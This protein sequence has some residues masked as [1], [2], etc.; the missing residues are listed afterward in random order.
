MSNI[1]SELISLDH[2]TTHVQLLFPSKLLHDS[3][4]LVVGQDNLFFGGGQQYIYNIYICMPCHMIDNFS[5][6]PYAF[7]P[8]NCKSNYFLILIYTDIYIWMAL[9]LSRAKGTHSH[10][11]KKNQ[12]HYFLVQYILTWIAH[13]WKMNF[14]IFCEKSLTL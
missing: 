4:M 13:G 7:C 6:F 10:G 11:A 12:S 2:I 8:Q 5:P 3:L 1:D 14:R 9:G